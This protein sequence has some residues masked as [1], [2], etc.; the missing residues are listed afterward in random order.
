MNNT[1]AKPQF[2][3]DELTLHLIASGLI[4]FA[5]K[6]K[7]NQAPKLPYEIEIQRGLDRI[8]L[9]CLLHS[10]KPP[11][12]IPDLISWCYKPLAEW[13]PELPEGVILSNDKLLE[14]GNPTELCEEFAVTGSDVEAEITQQQLLLNVIRV[15]RVENAQDSYVAFRRLLIEKPVLTE[16]DLL[17]CCTEP[18]LQLLSEQIRNAYDKAPESYALNG[19]FHC[20]RDCGNLMLLTV[21]QELVCT[22]ERC[23]TKN[24]NKSNRQIPVKQQ[25]YW[26]KRGLRR[27]IA[28]PGIAELRLADKLEKLGV[29]VQLWHNFDAYDLRIIFPDGE[30]WAVDVK[31][32][33]NPFL[34]ARNISQAQPIPHDGWTK[35]YFVFPNHR[36]KQRSD[37]KRAFCNHCRLPTNIKVKFENEMVRD[38]KKKLARC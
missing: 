35:G 15:C 11:Q 10:K 34:L 3:K 30:C 24:A 4:K 14:G 23:R 17:Q 2:S 6:V 37:Y 27:F 36:L 9:H 1:G 16:F 5:E 33:V 25:V 32:W 28:A 20:C 19:Y 8:V 22:Q 13:F 29:E 18:S 26:L 38:V 21:N 31:D 7:N 12:G